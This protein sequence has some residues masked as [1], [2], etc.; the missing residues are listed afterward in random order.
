MSICNCVYFN[1][2]LKKLYTK[3]SK[4]SDY[5]PAVQ[6]NQ[7]DVDIHKLIDTALE[8]KDLYIAIGIHKDFT[9]VNIYPHN[10]NISRWIFNEN[11]D[12]IIHRKNYRCSECGAY[13]NYPT[14]YCPTCGEKL[15]T[16]E[17]DNDKT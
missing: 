15:T 11:E 5:I 8:N 13:N 3:C 1:N 10:E 6:T 16:M 12:D 2:C 9:M 17:A 7:T 4:C 14:P